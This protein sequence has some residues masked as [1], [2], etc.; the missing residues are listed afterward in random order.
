MK[1][2]HTS[3]W[4]LGKRLFKSERLPEQKLF[5]DWLLE[6]LQT[7]NIDVLIV[8]GDVFDVP[9]PPN[10][11]QQLFYDFVFNLRKIEHLTTIIIG[12]NHDSSTLLQIPQQFF[13]GQNCFIKSG[14][15]KNSE[16]SDII[17]EKNGKSFGFKTLPYFR[18]FELLNAIEKDDQIEE[19]FSD[20]FSTWKSSK[21]PDYKFLI[22]HHV[23][24]NYEMSG[25]EHAIHLSGIDHFPLSWVKEKFDYV[26]LGHI[27]KKMA[28]SEEPPIIYP[29]S[30]I[31]M[32]FSESPKKQVSLITVQEDSLSYEML[33]I[34]I[35]RRLQKLKLTLENYQAEIKKTILAQDPNQ[36][37]TFLEVVIALDA[38]EK[39]L[40]DTVRELL[41][42]SNI[43]L[44][45]FVPL[46][47]SGGSNKVK[48][49][50]V[51]NLSIEELFERYFV[52]KYPNSEIPED[53]ATSFKELLDDINH[54]NS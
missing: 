54:E 39:G 15:Q 33:E 48:S 13:A 10:A 20:F 17:I 46:I 27:H 52:Q 16:G 49:E 5:L 3:D 50:V 19:Y 37:S 4:H 7:Q 29:G 23:F 28:M 44:L 45:S 22:A 43:E 21:A 11:A 47:S 24:G 2:L 41:K 25:S 32:R 12:G 8:A 9:S 26:A 34:P 51:G 35:F 40:A 1:I 42:D 6:T 14:L 31:P 53:I 18:N 38:P 36:L 30:P